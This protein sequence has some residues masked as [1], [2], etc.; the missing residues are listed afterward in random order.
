MAAMP[1]ERATG[2]VI[3]G[4]VRPET[5]SAPVSGCSAPVMILIRVDLPAPFSPTSAWTSPA[6][7]SK[8]TSRS[9]RTPSKDLQMFDAERSTDKA[10]QDDSG[11]FDELNAPRRP[12]AL[13]VARFRVGCSADPQ[14]RRV[15]QA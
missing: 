3:R 12:E 13:F 6:L 5:T 7:S 10:V 14:V 11:I 4:T 9:A 2:G 15:G 1:S 8:D